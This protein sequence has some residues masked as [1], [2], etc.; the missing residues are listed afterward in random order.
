MRWCKL[1]NRRN[2]PKTEEKNRTSQRYEYECF[3]NDV[4]I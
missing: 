4:A 1:E 3:V 2:V